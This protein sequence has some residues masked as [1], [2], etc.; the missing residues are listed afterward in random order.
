MAEDTHHDKRRKTS[1]PPSSSTSWDQDLPDDLWEFIFSYLDQDHPRRLEPVSLVSK[2]FLTLSNRARASLTLPSSINLFHVLSL[3]SRFPL[4]RTIH[5]DHPII[6]LDAYTTLLAHSGLP[7][8]SLHLSLQTHFPKDAMRLLGRRMNKT[9]K[10]LSCTRFDVMTD[11]DLSIV[12]DYFPY[13]QELDINRSGLDSAKSVTD[14]GIWAVSTKLKSLISLNIAGLFN[15]SVRSIECL[16]S[17]CPSLRDLVAGIWEDDRIGLQNIHS[18]GSLSS[19]QLH[20]VSISQSVLLQ[21]SGA[22]LNLWKLGLCSPQC[23]EDVSGAT[24]CGF[25]KSCRSL[26]HLL[27]YIKF[28]TDMTAFDFVASIPKIQAIKL[29]SY[30]CHQLPQTTLFHLLKSCPD[31]EDINIEGDFGLATAHQSFNLPIRHK[32]RKLNLLCTDIC[33]KTLMVIDSVCPKARI[34][35]RITGHGIWTV[36]SLIEPW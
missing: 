2:R 16:S 3:Y 31:L 14:R 24:I 4:I 30:G 27:L 8:Q 21:L 29:I 20:G 13:L 25:L 12:A 34:T 6:D 7:I 33:D 35:A 23:S 15:L 18:F 22:N 10:S 9:L 5:H 19:L 17:N 11:G 28:P 26:R 1:R 32:I 36:E